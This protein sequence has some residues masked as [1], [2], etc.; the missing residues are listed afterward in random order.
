MTFLTM[1]NYEGVW[2]LEES[3]SPYGGEGMN[4]KKNV[5]GKLQMKWNFVNWELK[6]E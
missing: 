4:S 1:A 5:F 3:Y 2:G 6:A